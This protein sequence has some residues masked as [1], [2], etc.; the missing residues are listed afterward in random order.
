MFK[1]QYWLP[2]PGGGT[3]LNFLNHLYPRESDER[4]YADESRSLWDPGRRSVP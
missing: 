2:R 1:G 3:Q 4:L